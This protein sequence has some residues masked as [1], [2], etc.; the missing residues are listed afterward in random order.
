MSVNVED[1]AVGRAFTMLQ[2]SGGQVWRDVGVVLPYRRAFNVLSTSF[3]SL[4]AEIVMRHTVPVMGSETASGKPDAKR[5][6]M[7]DKEKA[8]QGD[9]SMAIEAQNQ[10]NETGPQ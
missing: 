10:G 7:D 9:G 2:M 5:A 4:P 8:P 6:K 3:Y 1:Y